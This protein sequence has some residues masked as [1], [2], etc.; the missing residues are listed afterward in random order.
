M[1]W[2]LL[3]SVPRVLAIAKNTFVEAARNRAFLGLGIAA[4]ALVV[5]SMV[6][7]SLAISDQW[8]RVLIDFGLFTISLLEVVIAIVLGVILVYKEIDRKTFYLVL[9]KPVRRTEVL[10]GK[11]LGLLAV[12]ALSVVVMGCAWAVS[13]AARNVPLRPD[14]VKALVLVWMEASLVTST[15]LFFSSFATPV[16]SGVFTLGVFVVGSDID[17]LR[18]LLQ[19]T[20]G[21]LATNAG[22]RAIA[23][24]TVFAFP[25][26]SVFRVGREL[27]V[28]V[29]VPWDYV[30]GAAV[31]CLGYCLLFGALGALAFRRRDFV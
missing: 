16:M 29:P 4:V 11:F 21:A 19:S 18:E 22:A 9:P 30:G 6:V 3:D 31:Y 28:G 8:A 14:M 17:I 10:A 24:A 25:D 20:K 2:P 7:S 1:R 23:E 13:L 27:I 15:A 12:L 26:L 5:S